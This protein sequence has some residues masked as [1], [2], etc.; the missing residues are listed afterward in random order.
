MRP[1]AFDYL[2]PTSLDEALAML[3]ERAGEARV[4]SGGQSLV[5]IMNLRLAQPE[6][7]V[8]IGRIPGLNSIEIEQNN[9]RIGAMVTHAQIEYS[10]PL[11]Q[12]LPILPSIAR[13]IAHPAIRNRGTFG[14][15]LAHADPASEWP[16]MLL[17]MGG[18]VTATG[19]NGKRRIEA[20]EFFQSVL[21]T[22]LDDNEILTAIDLP[23]HGPGWHWSFYEIARQ[24]GA[25]G[26]VLLL[27]GADIAPDG[28]IRDLRLSVGGC[29]PCP[30]T[31]I[32]DW[33]FMTGTRPSTA[34]IVRAAEQVMQTIEPSGD[35]HANADD[36][37]QMAATLTTRALTEL[38]G[39]ATEVDVP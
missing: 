34:A 32:A 9:I 18:T 4:L 13:H 37:R 6:T 11:R 1:A 5:P 22:A 2:V 8:D 29:G 10:A 20:R 31:P 27:A 33:S 24:P 23:L 15:S 35:A 19:P 36:R 30:V 16:C 14:G 17:A 25:F 12:T 3:S 28:S 39:M 26:L 7:L 21:T 38:V